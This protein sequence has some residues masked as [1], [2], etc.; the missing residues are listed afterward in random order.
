MILLNIGTKNLTFIHVSSDRMLNQ[1]FSEKEEV[2]LMHTFEL[3]CLTTIF[4]WYFPAEYDVHVYIYYINFY[5]LI[6]HSCL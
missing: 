1:S 2:A 6:I 5:L 3:C 4:V